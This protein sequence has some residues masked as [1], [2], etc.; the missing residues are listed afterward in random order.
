M[1]SIFLKIQTWMWIG[2]IA[3]AAISTFSPD[4]IPGQTLF[5][6]SGIFLLYGL[7]TL[8]VFD[9]AD[10]FR[11]NLPAYAKFLDHVNPDDPFNELTRKELVSRVRNLFA[12]RVAFLWFAFAYV[13]QSAT[14]FQENLIDTTGG[15]PN[16]IAFLVYTMDYIWTPLGTLLDG[17]LSP[18]I[19]QIVPHAENAWISA[20]QFTVGATTT[21]IISSAFWRVMWLGGLLALNLSSK[22]T[23]AELK[24][25]KQ[26]EVLHTE[27]VPTSAISKPE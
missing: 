20:F 3:C 21:L 18:V 2:L 22:E 7:V 25:M 19:T 23:I 16:F 1:G 15:T 5:Y 14:V 12:W 4:W 10:L 6:C 24:S 27:A 11:R 13:A 8:F 26:T 17:L 9:N